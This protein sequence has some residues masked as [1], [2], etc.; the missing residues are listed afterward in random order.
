MSHKLLYLNVIVC[1]VRKKPPPRLTTRTN[2]T[3]MT[4]STYSQPYFTFSPSIKHFDGVS[5][6]H[7][8]EE[9]DVIGRL[10]DLTKEDSFTFSNKQTKS[11]GFFR[12]SLPLDSITSFTPE[13]EMLNSD[14]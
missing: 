14:E 7:P 2:K 9:C 6:P 1:L 13:E 5:R 11:W 3:E 8:W 12:I 4:S 10:G